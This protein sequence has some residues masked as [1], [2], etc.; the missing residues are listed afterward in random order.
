MKLGEIRREIANSTI[1]IMYLILSSGCNQACDYCYLKEMVTYNP[2][3]PAPK[4]MDRKTIKKAIDLFKGV[5]EGKVSGPQIVLYGGE[6]LI[7]PDIEFVLEYASQQMGGVQF[8]L[9]TNGT[10]VTPKLAKLL[11]QYKVNVGISIDGPEKIHNAHRIFKNGRGA[12]KRAKM[13]NDLLSSAQAN[14]SISCTVSKE[15]AETLRSTMLWILDEFGAKGVDFNLLIGESDP[16]YAENAA[17]AM[18]QCFELAKERGFYVD[19]V[20][21]HVKPFVDGR[22]HLHDCGANGNQIVVTPD[23][24][25]GI[26]QAFLNSGEN[27]FPMAE[28][29]EPESHPLWKA[30]KQRSPFNIQECFSCEAL[31]ICGGGC[32]YDVYQNT[33]NIMGV[34]SVHCVYIKKLLSFLLQDLWSKQ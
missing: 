24:R 28:V 10:L 34:S 15:S 3:N 26:C 33:G 25:I 14:V 21:R 7:N 29:L 2:A 20:M 11:A 12:F 23:E 27:F 17:N 5:V 30:W 8:V 16:K 22:V 31:G 18:I 1:S 32:F 4:V 6:P 9:V 13:G 19:R